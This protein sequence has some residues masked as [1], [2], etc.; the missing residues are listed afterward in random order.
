MKLCEFLHVT[1]RKLGK[2]R[3]EDPL[4]IS[5]I[6][7]HIIWEAKE[8]EKAHKEMERKSKAKKSRRR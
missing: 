6:E 3:R 8:R 5:F 2:L 7:R 1:P 4:G